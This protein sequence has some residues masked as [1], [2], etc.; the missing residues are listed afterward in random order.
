MTKITKLSNFQRIYAFC[1]QTFV[2]SKV[3][4]GQKGKNKLISMLKKGEPVFQTK[5][6]RNRHRNGQN[7]DNYPIF[8][9]FVQFL[10]KYR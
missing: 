2:N 9:F 5:I 10:S 3:E 6:V 7:F 1:F 8:T 4:K